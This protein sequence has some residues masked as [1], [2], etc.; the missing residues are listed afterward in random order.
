[1]IEYSSLRH[2]IKPHVLFLKPRKDR[3]GWSSVPFVVGSFRERPSPQAFQAPREIYR[4]SSSIVPFG[5]I[6]FIRLTQL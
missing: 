3:V 2:G 1:M 6:R 5:H 4:L